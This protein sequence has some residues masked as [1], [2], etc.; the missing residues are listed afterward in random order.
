VL[1]PAAISRSGFFDPVTVG[2]LVKKIETGVSI[3]ETDDMALAGIIATQL[4]HR[5]FVDHFP[6]SR[7]LP[8]NSSV[9]ICRSLTTQPDPS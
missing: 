9:K 7:S 3:G 1:T 6:R 4:L 8:A 5:Q 2:Q